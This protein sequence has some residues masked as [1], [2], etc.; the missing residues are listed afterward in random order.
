MDCFALLS[1]GLAMTEWVDC[2]DLPLASLAM[3]EF[4]I[5]RFCDSHKKTQNLAM[6]DYF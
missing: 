4:L 5:F 3:T 1:Q 2:H 6:T